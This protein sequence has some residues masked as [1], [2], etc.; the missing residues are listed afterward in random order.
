MQFEEKFWIG[1][2][3]ARGDFII[4]HKFL[5]PDMPMHKGLFVFDIKTQ[6]IVWE[7]DSL[8]FS[9]ID[10]NFIYA[11]NNTFD[12]KVFYK[13]NLF[14]GEILE[15]FSE[16]EVDKINQLKA[17]AKQEEDYLHYLFP[18][19]KTMQSLDDAN[20]VKKIFY[21][22]SEVH[23]LVETI[24]YKDVFFASLHLGNVNSGYNHTLTA[25]NDNGKIIFN[26]TLDKNITKIAPDT[27]FILKNKLFILKEKK[28]LQI[29]TIS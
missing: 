3:A 18:Q 21:G 28:I 1:I 29:F 20:P 22:K 11:F 23:D 27:F 8:V 12:G 19:K 13:L 6:K 24:E 10:D 5:K 14:N 7:N 2:E 4:F 26:E 15:E 16:N 25:F 17:L 9:F